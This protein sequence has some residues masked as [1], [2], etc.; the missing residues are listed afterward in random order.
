MTWYGDYF[1]GGAI[2]ILGLL[3]LIFILLI[4]RGIF[5]NKKIRTF[6]DKVVGFLFSLD[7]P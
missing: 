5:K 7:A 6:L 2:V 4:I 1:V 3:F